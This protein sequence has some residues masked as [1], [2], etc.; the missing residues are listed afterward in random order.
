MSALPSI[1]PTS[2]L[3]CQTA[4]DSL[5]TPLLKELKNALLE[6]ENN[7]SAGFLLSKKDNIEQNDI[8][9]IKSGHGQPILK[10]YK[11]AVVHEV[12]KTRTTLA[13][14][15]KKLVYI[16]ALDCFEE[17]NLINMGKN[18]YRRI[19]YNKKYIVHVPEKDLRISQVLRYRGIFNNNVPTKKSNPQGNINGG[20]KKENV[21]YWALVRT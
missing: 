18:R 4:F 1:Q 11:F 15:K 16:L 20:C 6:G 10:K 3:T 19:E 7:S 8:V 2:A 17:L 13:N 12:Q 5:L 14:G 9:Q 21:Q